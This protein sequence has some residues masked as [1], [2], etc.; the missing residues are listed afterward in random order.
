[1][2]FKDSKNPAASMTDDASGHLDQV[3]HQRSQP[4]MLA[5]L[6]AIGNQPTFQGSLSE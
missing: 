5:L 3:L 1:M 4:N 2:S 6:F